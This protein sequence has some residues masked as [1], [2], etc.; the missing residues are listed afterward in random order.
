M[1]SCIF[2]G[3]LVGKK[4]ASCHAELVSASL[5]PYIILAENRFAVLID[6]NIFSEFEV[7][8]HEHP[9]IQTVYLITDFE[10]G[11]KAMSQSLKVKKTYQ[12]YRDYL[13]NFRINVER[14]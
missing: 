10:K 8:V 14:N 1:Y 12:L 5:P 11:F 2:S 3:H 7:Q 9:E 4:Q 13:D 6:E